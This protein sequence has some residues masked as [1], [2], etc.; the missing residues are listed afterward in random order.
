V[1]QI[2]TAFVLE[3]DGGDY[4]V[5]ARHLLPEGSGP[6]RV[7]LDGYDLTSRDLYV[8]PLPGLPDEAD[9]AVSLLHESLGQT[10]PATPSLDGMQFGQDCY[11]LGYPYGLGLGGDLNPQMAFV[12]KAILSATDRQGGIHRLYLDGHNNPGFSGGPVVF[13]RDG[14]LG[15][16]CIAGVVSAYRVQE[17]T[18]LV[19][20]REL[21]NTVVQT[22]SGIVIAIEIGHVLAV[23]RGQP[24]TWPEPE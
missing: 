15:K 14:D 10:F 13:Y 12:K 22:N 21:P 7:E 16:P 17:D 20:G 1:G 9:V 6:F 4:L 2:G 24:T 5:T 11:F 8:D 3:V 19:A 18:V 23:I